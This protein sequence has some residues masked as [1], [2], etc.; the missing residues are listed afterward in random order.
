VVRVLHVLLPLTQITEVLLLE[1]DVRGGKAMA[2]DAS[3]RE[4]FVVLFLPLIGRELESVMETSR[5]K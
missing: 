3:T 2:F 5:C 4:M 1:I